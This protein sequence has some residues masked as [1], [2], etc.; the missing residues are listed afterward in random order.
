MEEDPQITSD[1]C[2]HVCTKHTCWRG[3]FRDDCHIVFSMNLVVMPSFLR[4]EFACRL[5]KMGQKF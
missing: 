1:A 4:C 2:V 5:K 3:I